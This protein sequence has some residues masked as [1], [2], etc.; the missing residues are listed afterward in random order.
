MEKK[1]V[2][3]FGMQPMDHQTNLPHPRDLIF[4]LKAIRPYIN[5]KTQQWVHPERN[6]FFHLDIACLQRH[7]NTI[8]IR[9]AT[10][11][12]DLFMKL[13][14]QQLDFLNEDGILAHFSK[15]KRKSNKGMYTC[16]VH[17]TVGRLTL[18]GVPIILWL[19]FYHGAIHNVAPNII[20]T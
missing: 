10:I 18:C 19:T 6:V 17:D 2:Q 13:S 20:C 5:P 11:T 9:A 3:V 7:N 14:R 16:K 8:E 1:Q 15:N 12:D 4:T